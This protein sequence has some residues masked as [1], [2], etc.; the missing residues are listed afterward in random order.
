MQNKYLPVSQDG[1]YYLFDCMNKSLI[2]CRKSVYQHYKDDVKIGAGINHDVSEFIKTLNDSECFHHKENY[3]YKKVTRKDLLRNL[4]QVR[5]IALE[6]TEQCNLH[7]VYCCYGDLFKKIQQ[8]KYGDRKKIVNYL[9]TLLTLRAEQGNQRPL[10]IT[11]Y[12]GEALL[13]FDIIKECVDLSRKILTKTELSFGMTTNGVLLSRNL[14][15]LVENGFYITISLDGD[16][17]NNSYRITRGNREIFGI[18]ERNIEKI[19]TVYPMFFEKHITFNTVLHDRSSSY[20]A[21][22]YFSKWNKIPLFSDMSISGGKKNSR[23]LR[24]ISR[25]KVLTND[26]RIELKHKYPNITETQYSSKNEKAWLGGCDKLEISDFNHIPSK[27]KYIYPGGSCYMFANRVF[28]TVD[29]YLLPCE[30]VSRKFKFGK[31]GQ[32]YLIFY[33]KRINQYYNNI[34]STFSHKCS[35][36]YEMFSCK[37]CFFS[38][39]DEIESG[40][41]RC[42]KAQAIERISK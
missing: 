29:G 9:K 2:P 23:L 11:F 12:G 7:C 1:L 21:F 18:V 24:Q 16:R 13:R 31:I 10:R 17:R 41:C 5:Q 34:L 3:R 20:E 14:K 25:Q 6:V 40:Y 42:E 32:R 8:G 15:Y 4:G 38:D 27:E 35:S 28:V 39:I 22:C 36:C 19:R 30:K 33:S 26:E 37:K